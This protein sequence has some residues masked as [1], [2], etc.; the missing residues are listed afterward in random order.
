VYLGNAAHG[1]GASFP[2]HHASVG[3]DELR[4]LDEPEATASLVSCPQVV[5]V[6]GYDGGSLTSA[7]TVN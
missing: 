3:A 7:A 2:E 5:S 1:F 6:H 4:V